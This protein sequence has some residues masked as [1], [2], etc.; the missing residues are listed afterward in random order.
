MT[1][2]TIRE[3]G[4][5]HVAQVD[6]GALCWNQYADR[7]SLL[8]AGVRADWLGDHTLWTWRRGYPTEAPTNPR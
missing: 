5:P 8:E 1:L 6:F 2:P 4:S 3:G 7:R